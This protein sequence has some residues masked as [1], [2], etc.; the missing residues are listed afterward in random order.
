M[1]TQWNTGM[2]G[3]VGLRYESIPVALRQEQIPR[4]QWSDVIDG[5]Q[6][7]EQETLRI[8]REKR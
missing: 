8:W 6:V 3:P 7:M 2:N 1:R 4:D 5:V